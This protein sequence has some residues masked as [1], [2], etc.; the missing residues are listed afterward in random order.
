MQAD[1]IKFF[2]IQRQ[3]F[4]VCTCCGEI[5]RL[6]DTQVYLK[7]KPA[8]DWMD[9]LDASELRLEKQED[10]LQEQKNEI[11]ATAREKGR[12]QAMRSV[13]KVDKV[14][15]PNKL[16]PDDAKVI[17]HPVDYVVF[18]GMKEKPEL[19]NII[20]LD[21]KVKDKGQKAI[22]KSVEK[23]ISKENYEWITVHVAEDGKVEYR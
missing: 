12:K 7:E 2:S 18:N 14:F 6:S 21:R 10:K 23:T 4:G 1:M 15:T 11:Q 8:D 17:F 19:K 20:F 5:F 22:Q 16:N 13:K 9:K 3:I